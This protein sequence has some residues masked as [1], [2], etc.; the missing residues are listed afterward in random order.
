MTEVDAFA[1]ASASGPAI[2]RNW[3]RPWSL[4]ELKNAS[5]KW[6]LAADAGV[7]NHSALLALFLFVG[8]MVIF[9]LFEF[10]FF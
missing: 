5:G 9:F 6:N 1:S 3:E 4:E 10:V 8:L 7:S 2:N